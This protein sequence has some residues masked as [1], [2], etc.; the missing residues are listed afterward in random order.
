[1]KRTAEFCML[2][3]TVIAT[4]VFSA[5]INIPGGIDDLKKT[6]LFEPNI[7][8]GICNIGWSCFHL[9]FNCNINTLTSSR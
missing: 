7:I 9:I 3:S 4:A 5:A 2:I 1:M 6:K 8:F